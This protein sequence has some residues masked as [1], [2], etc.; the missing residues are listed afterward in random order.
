MKTFVVAALAVAAA[1]GSTFGQDVR[2]DLRLV[3]QNRVVPATSPNGV[4][5]IDANSSY[6]ATP[7]EQIRFELQYRL[8]DL[9][10]SD[11]I[12]PAG[13]TGAQIN[14]TLP[15]A[16]GSFARA[17][18]SGAE[19]NA[20][21]RPPRTLGQPADTVAWLGGTAPD[22][23]GLGGNPTSRTGLHS[24]FRGGMDPAD[25]NE[26]P[27]NGQIPV[28]GTGI[29][30]IT[31]LALSQSNQGRAGFD[32]SP[33][34]DGSQLLTGGEWYGIY[35]FIYTVGQ[36]N[37]IITASAVADAASGNRFAFFS[38]GNPVPQDQTDATNGAYAIIVPAPGSMALLGLGAL[39][40][41]RRRRA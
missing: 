14:I 24:P 3:R 16:V 37:S 12:V 9:N 41:G 21:A 20:G 38:N 30:N 1:A 32:L 4:V 40:A 29:F 7:G 35:S 27:S 18:T 13:L 31:P 22:N 19:T 36:S 6:T 10:T 5:D 23:S 28:G 15:V 34:Q 33:D 25:N 11:A 39:I 26:L 17:L 8:V 2:L